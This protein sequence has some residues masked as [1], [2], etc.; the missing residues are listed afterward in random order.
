MMQIGLY[1]NVLYGF[2]TRYVSFILSLCGNKND[3]YHKIYGTGHSH[4]L[5]LIGNCLLDQAFQF[6]AKLG[7]IFEQCFRCIATLCQFRAVV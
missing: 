7:I 1:D 3:R 6:F 5:G 4:A 2:I